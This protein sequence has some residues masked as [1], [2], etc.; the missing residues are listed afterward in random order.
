MEL[1]EMLTRFGEM[2]KQ[3]DML[4]LQLAELR[5]ARDAQPTQRELFD[6]AVGIIEKDLEY[7][8]IEMAFEKIAVEHY[9]LRDL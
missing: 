2:V 8:E 4:R 3:R 9:F 6:K 7:K 1:H 5:K